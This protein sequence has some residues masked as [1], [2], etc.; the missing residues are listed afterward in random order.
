MQVYSH[1]IDAPC[2]VESSTYILD[3]PGCGGHG[4]DCPLRD[5][6]MTMRSSAMRTCRRSPMDYTQLRFSQP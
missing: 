3:I 5:V 4:S 6:T 1:Q 2:P